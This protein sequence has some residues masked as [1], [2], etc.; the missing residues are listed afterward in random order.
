M[1]EDLGNEIS[2]TN[3]N[4][5]GPNYEIYFLNT[6]LKTSQANADS[7]STRPERSGL[8][9]IAS[10]L[11]HFEAVDQLLCFPLTGFLTCKGIS[12][13]TQLLCCY[14]PI[15]DIMYVQSPNRA[16]VSKFMLLYSP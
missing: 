16:P 8:A 14:T 13:C 12:S 11:L 9:L 4:G 3:I 6:T 7:G 2:P 10:Y 15:S 5:Y 1:W